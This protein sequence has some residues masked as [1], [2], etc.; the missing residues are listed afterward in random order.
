MVWSYIPMALSQ[1]LAVYFRVFKKQNIPGIMSIVSVGLNVILNYM[2]IYGKFGM[3]RL[4]VEGAAL[5]TAISRYI[6]FFVLFSILMIFHHGKEIFKTSSVRLNLT[7]KLEIMKTV[8]YTHLNAGVYN[9]EGNV[10]Y[11]MRDFFGA[12]TPGISKTNMGESYDQM[13]LTVVTMFVGLFIIIILAQQGVKAAV[14]LGM[15]GASALYWV[16]EAIVF[17]TNPF[18]G[19]ATA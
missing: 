3:P 7:K 4:E 16:I 10:F 17:N 1:M 12:L 11:V 2:L 13:V 5:A 15:L 8:S 19:L 9:A 14:I 6:E 18:A